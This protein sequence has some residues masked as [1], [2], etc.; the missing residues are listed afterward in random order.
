MAENNKKGVHFFKILENKLV[1]ITLKLEFNRKIKAFYRP[2]NKN[3][4]ELVQ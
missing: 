4:Y 3:K 1:Q 2:I